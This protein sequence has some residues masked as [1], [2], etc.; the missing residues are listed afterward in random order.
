MKHTDG[1]WVVKGENLCSACAP[2]L[3]NE[4]RFDQVHDEPHTTVH[5]NGVRRRDLERA[6][7]A[8]I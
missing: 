8:E 1:L 5:I 4:F 2:S 6:T 7:N 3:G